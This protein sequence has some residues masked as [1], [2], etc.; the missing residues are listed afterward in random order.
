MF[1]STFRRSLVAAL[2]LMTLAGC[3]PLDDAMVL[4]FGRSMRD[5]RS[6]DPYENTRPAPVGSVAFSAGNYPA[7]DGTVNLG[8]PA[9]VAIPYFTQTDLGVPGVGGPV[10]QGLAN[11]TDPSDPASLTR[12]EEIY[13]R[14]C[15]VCHGPD[16]VGA[17]AYITPDKHPTLQVYNLSG[18]QVAGYS[19]Q[20]LYAILRVGRGLMPE[21]GSRIAHF[22]RWHVVNYVRQLQAQAGNVPAQGEPDGDGG[23]E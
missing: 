22:D 11:P 4:V 9:G 13:L 14:F 7:E 16:G 6:F 21:Y 3:K 5:Q 20:Y 12:G 18:A 19:D 1:D 17:N 8:Q 10:V 15:V 2:A 23:D